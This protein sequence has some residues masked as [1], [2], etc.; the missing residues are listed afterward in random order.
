MTNSILI[1]GR[2][3]CVLGFSLLM[4]TCSFTSN[5]PDFE[6]PW[7]PEDSTSFI[8]PITTIITTNVDGAVLDTHTIT[9]VWMGNAPDM[10]FHASLNG[11]I[12]LDWSLDTTITISW[13]DEGTY[14]FEIIG[15]YNSDA[16]EELPVSLAFE[17]N[18]VTGPA[19]MFK[20][21]MQQ[22]SFGETFTVILLAEEVVDL[23]ALETEIILDNPGL[24]VVSVIVID[25]P[26]A[27][28]TKNSGQVVEITEISSSSIEIALGIT[29]SNPEGVSGSGELIEVVLQA[30]Q[31]GLYEIGLSNES[32]F[33]NAGLNELEFL[34]LVSGW[35]EVQ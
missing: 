11:V 19:L 10:E 14:E 7:N 13:L 27:F 20:P 23:M 25:D 21:R 35:V 32:Q 8:S 4:L 12:L 5:E 30:N 1:R 3:L 29:N 33:I 22:V 18:D 26:T 31:P 9:I 16:V 2:I 28:L 17:I 15:R 34:D 6:N 24:Q